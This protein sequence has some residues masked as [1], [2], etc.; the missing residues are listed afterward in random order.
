M[1]VKFQKALSFCCWLGVGSKEESW[2]IITLRSQESFFYLQCMEPL[3]GAQLGTG[4]GD[5]AHQQC[6]PA[7]A[8]P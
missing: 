1:G 8:N 2:I 4:P 3:V 6:P 5:A 7:P